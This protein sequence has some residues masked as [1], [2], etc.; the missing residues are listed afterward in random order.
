MAGIINTNVVSLDAQRQLD[1]NSGTLG[2]VLQRLSSGLRINSAKD[3]AAGLAISERFT[4]QVSGLD[5][6]RRNAN[7]GVS[8]AQ[9]AEGALSQMGDILQR[10][11]QLAVQSVNATN[12]ASDRQ[13]LNQESTQLIQELNRFAN[14]TEFNG[15]KLFDGTFG[16][17]SYQVGANANQVITATSTNLLADQFGTYQVG[18]SSQSNGTTGT[19]LVPASPPAAATTAQAAATAAAA[20]VS[21]SAGVRAAWSATATAWGLTGAAADAA[22]GTAATAW[23]A[24]GG[25]LW[26]D[27]WRSFCS[28]S[29]AKHE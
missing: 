5:Q 29:V 12:T 22:W 3:D 23:G 27:E 11:R 20:D 21:L 24:S 8:L 4:A 1:K 13:A 2:T 9:T 18:Y 26:C 7:D 28:A 6:A 15:Q 25:G 17:A 19:V 16:S 10:V 14:T